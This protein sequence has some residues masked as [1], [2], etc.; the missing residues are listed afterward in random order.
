[1]CGKK[2]DLRKPASERGKK[3]AFKTWLQKNAESSL[4]AQL[5]LASDSTVCLLCS[6]ARECLEPL[7][8]VFADRS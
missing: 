4:H 3:A 2:Y 8:I 7:L 5:G 1:M 6:D